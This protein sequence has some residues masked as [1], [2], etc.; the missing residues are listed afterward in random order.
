VRPATVVYRVDSD[1]EGP[2]T[3]RSQGSPDVIPSK[4]RHTR[5]PGLL[6]KSARNAAEF[7]G[8]SRRRKYRVTSELISGQE[9]QQESPFILPQF[10]VTGAD[11]CVV[12]SL[13]QMS[14]T[15]A[16]IRTR[17]PALTIS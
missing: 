16:K 7:F 6:A 3:F 17:D 5:S 12:V 1:P 15:P 9:L 14:N 11:A 8:F 10:A 13:S 4:N 2:F